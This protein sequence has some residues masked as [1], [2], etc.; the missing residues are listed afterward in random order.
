MPTHSPATSEPHSQTTSPCFSRR[1]DA[2]LI[3]STVTH[4]MQYRKG[5]GIPYSMHPVHVAHLLE[6][7]GADEDIVIAGLLHDVLEDLDVN[8][9][10][11]RKGFR[12]AYPTRDWS[13]GPEEF[14]QQVQNLIAS[15]FGARVLELV[16]TVTERKED[17]GRKRPWKAR[18]VEQLTELA[19]GSP[20][21]AVLKCA[22]AL[23]NVSSIVR[24]MQDQPA[25]AAVSVLTR[26][27]ASPDDVLWLYGTVAAVAAERIVDEHRYLARELED[28]IRTLE[29]EIDRACGVRNPFTGERPGWSGQPSTCLVA[30]SPSGRRI[31]SVDQ[32]RRFAPP[33]RGDAQWK[34]SRSAKELA[35][36]WFN[37]LEATIPG[38]VA[39]LFR[40]SNATA[41]LEVRTIFAEHQT[42]LDDRGAGRQHDL[43]AHGTA[44]N[45]RVVIGFEAKADEPFGRT[46][47]EYLQQTEA[48]NETRTREGRQ[49]SG[50]PARINELS[51]RVFGRR[52]DDAISGLRY[53]LLHATAAVEL[54][55]SQADLAVF[56]VHE[57]MSRACDQ[58]CVD[59]NDSDLVHFARVLDSAIPQI[60]VGGIVGPFRSAAGSV[61]LYIGK[62]RRR[63]ATE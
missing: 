62:A 44:G 8:Y 3:L 30:L 41:K 29:Q 36:A 50:V 24:D 28:A 47:G 14:V 32:W 4:R 9:T 48:E 20:A 59:T 16:G 52:V 61:P 42:P 6:R 2:A 39:E 23:H 57:F 46:V 58:R 11:V 33:A 60:E 17:A 49:V 12:K 13:D 55:A 40:S 35:R 10:D 56:A 7:A 53:Q 45:T 34:D 37:G 5:T 15:Q 18:K 1:Y 43:L 27:N 31:Y 22:D 19:A 26:F 25:D 38:E 54:E 63:L 21:V 51:Q